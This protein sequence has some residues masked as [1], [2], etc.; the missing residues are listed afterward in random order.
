MG[1]PAGE[2]DDGLSCV[3]SLNNRNVTGKVGTR[4]RGLERPNKMFVGNLVQ[5]APNRQPCLLLIGTGMRISFDI[6]AK[7]CFGCRKTSPF[8]SWTVQ[9]GRIM[10]KPGSR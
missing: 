6:A 10:C 8:G 1:I 7:I 4:G 9:Q 3:A 2:N 5:A